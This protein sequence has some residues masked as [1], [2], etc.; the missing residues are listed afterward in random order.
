VNTEHH[1]R[2]NAVIFDLDGTLIDS[3]P[4]VAEALNKT[5][6][7]VQRSTLSLKM[8]RKFIGHGARNMIQDALKA[9][10]D[11]NIET[12]LDDM[13]ER[14]LNFYKSDPTSRTQVYPGVFEVLDELTAAHLR[15]GICTNKP[16]VMADIVLNQLKLAPYF[17]GMTAGDDVEHPKPD[18]RHI[19]QT[20]KRMEASSEGAVMV[21]DSQSDLAAARDAGIGAVA[22][23]YGYFADS[24][25]AQYIDITIDK[26]ADLPSALQQLQKSS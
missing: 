14:Y 22:V 6:E 11:I 25:D 9:T 15:L 17:C 4:D 20:L 26:M 10:G 21:G 3:A 16:S 2:H 7:S 8:I 19:S 18:G 5:L 13:I 24:I 12:S 23:S 1:H